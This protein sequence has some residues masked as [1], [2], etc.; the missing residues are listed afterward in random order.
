MFSLRENIVRD[1][2]EYVKSFL[3]IRDESIA[4]FVQEK[5]DAG[6]LWPDALVQLNPAYEYGPSIND[7]VS[8]G[9]L[10]PLCKEIFYGFRL[11]QHQYQAIEVALRRENYVVTTGTGSGKSMTYL[12]P[13]IDHVLKHNPEDGRV[14][15]IIVYP[16]NALI[17]SQLNAIDSLAKSFNERNPGTQF[18]ITY[19]RYTGQESDEE[20]RSIRE[21][22]PHILLTNYVMLELMLTRPEERPFVDRTFTALEFL[23]FDELH[24]YRGRQGA[25][26]A[27]LIRRLRERCGNPDLIHIGTS[28]TMIT[29]GNL[30]DQQQVVASVA[31]KIFGVDVKPENIITETLKPVFSISYT[32]QQLAAA[33]LG[34]LPQNEA[35]FLQSP[36]A[37]WIERTFGLEEIGGYL[38]RRVPITLQEGAARL[39]AE[40]GIEM[41]TCARRL[42][43]MLLFGSKIKLPDGNPLFA[44][45]LHQFISQG[46][47]VY[48]T[49]ETK[50]KRQLTLVAQHYAPDGQK[51]LFPLVFCRECGQEYYL[52]ELLAQEKRVIPRPPETGAT[53]EEAEDGYLLL[54]EDGIW[55]DDLDLLP[56]NWFNI[57][58][59]G[60]KRLKR[61]YQPFVPR[62]LYIQPDGTIVDEPAADN[63]PCW[64]LPRPFL[65]CLTCGEVYTRRN[66]NEFRK[67]AHL[68]SEGRSTA[69][70]LL[71]ISAITNIRRRNLFPENAQKLLSFTDNRQ[72]A[73]LQAGHFNDFVEVAL[74][75]SSI[76]KALE[77][78]QALDHTNIAMK[79][80]DALALDQAAYAREVGTYGSLA[81]RNREILE[82]LIEYRIYEDLRRGWRVVQPNL[83]QC[84]L[85]RIDYD[86]LEDLCQDNFAWQNH[87]VLA[88]S[89]SEIRFKAV[90]A[91]L[92]Y[93][94]R[95]LAIHA[96]CLQPR[97]QESLRRR[98]REALKE[99]WTFEE[100][101]RLRQ[102]ACF[103]LPGYQTAGQ[104]IE[105]SL[106]PRSSLG[107]FL[108][109]KRTWGLVTN[110]SEASYQEFLEALLAVL[111][112]A[113]FITYIDGSE[114][115]AIQLR[116]DCLIW[117]LGDGTPLEPDPVWSRRIE[118]A[119]SSQVSRTVNAFFRDF[120]QHT[121]WHLRDLQAREH[122]GQ[123]SIKDRQE[124]EK[125]FKEGKL[126][127]LFCSPTMELGIDIAD[128]NLVHLRNI[129]PTPANYAQ[130]SGRAGRS[131]QPALVLSYCGASSGHDQYF[132]RQ[133]H[134]MVAGAVAPPRLDLG[135]EELVKAHVHAIWLAYTGLSLERAIPD[136]LDAENAAANYP[137]RDNV[138][139]QLNFSQQRF[140]ECFTS[141]REVL[142]SC[143]EELSAAEWYSEEW[144]EMV[145][146]QAPAE[147]DRAFDRW[148]QMFATA[149]RQL[150]E[151]RAIIDRS[152]V[153][154]A[155]PREQVEEAR[156]R[157]QEALRQKDL[158][159]CKNTRPEESDFYPYRYLASEG[160]L[161]GYNFPRLPLR[162]YIPKGAEGEFVVRPRFLALKEFGPRNIIYHEGNKYKVVRS[163]LPPG[164]IESRFLR[165]KL[166]KVCGYF[167]EGDDINLDLCCNCGTR[168]DGQT[169]EYIARLFEMTT[170]AT[171]RVER[172]TS[173]E[174]ERVLEGYEVTTHYRFAYGPGGPRVIK[175]TVVDTSGQSLLEMLYAPAAT[176]WRINHGWKRSR[177]VGFTLNTA[178]G[179]W[180]GRPEQDDEEPGL[181][182]EN[183]LTGVRLLVRDTHNIL[184]LKLP[185]NIIQNE[186]R[187]NA[188]LAA[189][190][191]ALQRGLQTLFQVEED[192]IA[193]ERIG[194][195]EHQ[196]IL[197]WEAAEGGVGVLGRLVAE[198]G[199]LARVAR[200]ALVICHFDPDSGADLRTGEDGCACACY[201][202][203]LSYYNQPDHPILN[204]HLAK[205]LLMRLTRGISRCGHGGRDYEQHYQWLRGLTD[206]RSE[207]ERRFLD[208]LYFT[209]RRLPDYAQRNLEDI[210]CCPDF[211]YEE[212]H[213]CVFCDGSIHDSPEQR[214]RDN[215]MRAELE[216]LGYRVIVIRYDQDLE[217]Q[218]AAY[219]DVFGEGK[220]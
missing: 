78:N 213:V 28:A 184:L 4:R 41:E 82:A 116:S 214:A 161:P 179:Y 147:F 61:E 139:A 125:L 9:L 109:D 211:Y 215:E 16:M 91:F 101:E 167:H 103:V 145:L 129:P 63:V 168:F 75:R 19:N 190:Q 74:L 210:Y 115:R 66:R 38:K 131:G 17:N 202:C 94:R 45:K 118:T 87:P 188:T 177:E 134:L 96:D 5:L 14:R 207:L 122:T 216:D 180:S 85:L 81:R 62:R 26:V 76:Y 65:L 97:Y 48:A 205:D 124:R 157:E 152:H 31:R 53:S 100:N 174:E 24:T 189:L 13:I 35:E 57:T 117:R 162:A 197:M 55:S 199:A 127:C 44:F 51:L 176:L 141:C 43:D 21:N 203:L 143:G 153:S 201:D 113:G 90:Y 42:Q 104:E 77:E 219:P 191:Y 10:H 92:N 218:V 49:L 108:R 23:V 37:A 79:V 80:T 212:G 172:I 54:D 158:L 120:Y 12:I 150:Q 165:A 119:T 32:R 187:E 144:L 114:G 200:E 132:F 142:A 71:S 98:V 102:A 194:E 34:P 40:T 111:R 27:L 93:L 138:Q 137:L 164:T 70:T 36:L 67:L 166:C 60:E 155:I 121:A 198:P 105:F 186:G 1:Y 133:P 208:Y 181:G 50:A 126:S 140:K 99:P 46:G 135:N 163:L 193:S 195:G 59:R 182:Q 72:D 29:G 69:T 185:R 15:A 8:R 64:F 7:L 209:G 170:V 206:T 73:S 39:A 20:K 107:R 173:D 183:I 175:A 18:P 136:I 130:R 156:Q 47:S 88:Q 204:R 33:V 171:R 110:L 106:G 112:G 148:R 30:A 151:A 196:A 58:N 11:Y 154:R 146:R 95:K 84:G 169:S 178:N 123:V 86:G 128:L 52:V 192:E 25:D 6:E 56:E 83:E 159:C 2:A 149:N 22:P 68:S 160:F 220:A 89:S 217:A 3:K